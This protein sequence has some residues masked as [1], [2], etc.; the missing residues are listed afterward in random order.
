MREVFE[1]VLPEEALTETIQAAHVQERRR[2][3]D[4]LE[5]VRA[6]VISAATGYGGRQADVTWLRFEVGA[7]ASHEPA[8]R[9]RL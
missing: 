4:V 3:V 5:F 7:A 9:R 6:M 2:P 8:G 1:S